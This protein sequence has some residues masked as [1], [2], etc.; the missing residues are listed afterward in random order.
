MFRSHIVFALGVLFL[1]ACTGNPPPQNDN[2]PLGSEPRGEIYKPN[3]TTP[4]YKAS[5]PSNRRHPGSPAWF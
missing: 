4:D 3:S 2:K 1:S 5:K